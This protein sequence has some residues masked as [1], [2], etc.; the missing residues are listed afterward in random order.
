MILVLLNV[1]YDVVMRYLFNN[2]SIGMQEMEWHL[3]AGMFLFGIAYTL[4]EDKHVRV[5][6]FYEKKKPKT[7]AWNDMIGCAIL[8][9]PMAIII[10]Y[11]GFGFALDAYL[12]EESSG[13]P[14]GLSMRWIVKSTISISSILIIL[15]A[16]LVILRCIKTIQKSG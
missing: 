1:F 15:S 3:F 8:V 14:G 2:V 4:A 16:L 9:I 5:D 7:Q 13:D 10:A 12:L 11:Y 6:I